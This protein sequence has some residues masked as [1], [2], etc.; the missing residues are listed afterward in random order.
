M[1]L[2]KLQIKKQKKLWLENI[3][4]VIVES[5]LAQKYSFKPIPY[6]VE[7]IIG[8]YDAPEKQEQGLVKYNLLQDGNTLIYGNN[9][10]E[11]EMFLDTLIYSTTK[12][13]SV[14]EINYYIVDYGS[15][16]L[17]KYV[18]LP[19]V[20]RCCMHR[21]RRKSLVIFLKMIKEEIRIRKKVFL[22]YG[23]DYT[24]YIKSSPNKLPIKVYI[25]NNYDSIYESNESLYEELPNLLRDSERY[26]IIFVITA[27]AIN[28]VQSKISQNLNNI[29]SYKLKDL[30]D[31]ITVLGTKVKN[32]P[33]DIVGRGIIK[34]EDV[35]HEF[36]TASI[37][38]NREMT[39]NYLLDY[40]NEKKNI[41]T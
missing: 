3:K 37:I 36:Q 28:S 38:D 4:E 24:N 11:R 30:S 2:L 33:P 39:N 15:E 8:E 17:K 6:N 23:G 29:Y 13:H 41:R 1:Q 35:A 34:Q 40:I 21:R 22:N 14:A 20:G 25:F 7:A 16:S 26:G 27:N 12:Y 10:A 5:D 19:H 18:N 32:M 31:Y 9:G